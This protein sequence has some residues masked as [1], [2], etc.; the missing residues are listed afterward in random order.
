MRPVA[1]PLLALVLLLGAAACG[2]DGASPADE[3]AAQARRAAEEAGLDGDVADF[4]ALAA[5]G[6]AAT[7]QATYPGPERGSTLV[8]ANRPPDRR[9][10]VLA[11]D[12]V[13]EIRFVLDGQAHECVAG[14]DGEVDDCT[15]TDAIVEPPGL[16]RE[17][18]LQDLTR[19][20][21]DRRDDF[22]FRVEEREVAGVDARCLVTEVR[23]GRDRPE[24]GDRG[25]LCVSPE[26]VVLL[27]EQG[28]ETLEASDYT[29]DLPE[30]TFTLPG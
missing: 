30:G 23:A 12:D 14:D 18:A 27:A 8:V 3:R 9:V 11:G 21:R 28:G 22:T 24:L 13:V 29:T 19:S 26:G 2:D 6:Q 25:E 16:F 1:R 5:R 10:D 7:Y 4:L 15:R 20:L 17:D